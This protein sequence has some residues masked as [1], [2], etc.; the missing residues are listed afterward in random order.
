[1]LVASLASLIS[2]FNRKSRRTPRAQKRVL[3]LEGLEARQVFDASFDSLITVGNDVASILPWD[4]GVDS[5][6]NNY[7]TGIIYGEMDFDPTVVRPDLSDVLTTQ[8]SSDGF[9]AKY[10]PNNE[11]LWARRMGSNYV[12]SSNNDPV[13]GARRL[14]VDSAGNVYV[15]GNFN[16]TANFGSS[17]LVSVGSADTFV[18]KLDTNGNFLWAKGWGTSSREFGYGVTVDGAGN[19]IAVG[20]TSFLDSNG[21]WT[22]TGADIKKFNSNGSLVWSKSISGNGANAG[23]VATD[24]S[25]NIYVAGSFAGTV[26]MNPDPKRSNYLTGSSV[27]SGGAGRNS[28][29]LKLTSAGVYSSAVSLTADTNSS[30]TSSV[31]VADLEI[32]SSGSVVLGGS[33]SGAVDFNPSPSVVYRLPGIS[34]TGSVGFVQKLTSSLSFVWA[35]ATAGGTVNDIAIDSTGIFTVGT[36]NTTFVFAGSTYASAGLSDVVITKVSVSGVSEWVLTFGGTQSETGNSIAVDSAGTLSVVGTFLG[37]TDFDPD[38][39]VDNQ[40]TNA[41]GSD[42]YLLKLRRR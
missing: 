24:S 16:G 5:A 1:M 42:M 26:D 30:A 18:T 12:R 20:A 10:G 19:V 21:A 8:G 27:V 7:V 39:L 13:E 9:V 35:N 34:T 33:T 36:Y 11:F 3:R 14:T 37:T 41:S 25:G 22:H 31:Y 28:Y 40:R 6:G 38:P 23:S 2:R 32:D 4:N 15:I 17:Q 29:I